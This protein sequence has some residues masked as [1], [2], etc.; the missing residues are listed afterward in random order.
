MRV[1]MWQIMN[2]AAQLQ[3]ALARQEPQSVTRTYEASS[4]RS[5]A[6]PSFQRAAQGMMQQRPGSSFPHHH[7]QRQQ[8]VHDLA[9][10]YPPQPYQPAA[11]PLQPP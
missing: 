3:H 4:A 2:G 7:M 10:A 11:R 9:A 8:H 1:T 6:G 5:M